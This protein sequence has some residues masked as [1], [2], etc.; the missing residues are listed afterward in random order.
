MSRTGSSGPDG[1]EPTSSEGDPAQSL[2]DPV[3]T[4]DALNVLQQAASTFTAPGEGPTT[5]LNGQNE[6]G[7]AA[8]GGNLA[9]AASQQASD[10]EPS[11]G[12]LATEA[13]VATGGSTLL[14]QDVTA[15]F[16]L[17][18][19]VY[20][21][22][23]QSRGRVVVVGARDSI[24]LRPGVVTTLLGEAISADPSNGAIVLK[25]SQTIQLADPETKRAATSAMAFS[26]FTD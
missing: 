19:Q 11:I 22:Q 5:I 26:T 15:S 25:G 21:A 10:Q 2:P 18:G 8:N 3:A 1:V 23:E 24:T 6:D 14:P 7:D 12:V 17:S 4:S 13:P 16:T 20:T 9:G